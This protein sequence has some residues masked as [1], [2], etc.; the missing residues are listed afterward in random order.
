MTPKLNRRSLF[1][2]AA[3]LALAPALA[4]GPVSL[5]NRC[6]DDAFLDRLAKELERDSPLPEALWP[7]NGL[8]LADPID[9]MTRYEIWRRV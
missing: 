6:D 7:S 4:P 8:L 5:P 2:A 9:P 3:G 1:A